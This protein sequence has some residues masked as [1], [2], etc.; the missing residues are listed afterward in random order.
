VIKTDNA[1]IEA[2]SSWVTPKNVHQVQQ[3]LGLAGYYRMFVPNF[4][5]IAHPLYQLTKSFVLWNWSLACQL[6][7]D[8]LKKLLISHPILRMPDFS[9]KFH[10]SCDA[11]G[12]A[13]GAILGQRDEDGKEYVICYI[14]RLLKGAELHYSV[15]EKEMLAVIWAIRQFRCYVYGREF[16]IITD[17]SALQYLLTVKDLNG[18]LAR[19][20]IYLQSYLFK[21][22]HRA[23][24]LHSNADALSRLA[25]YVNMINLLDHNVRNGKYD[26]VSMK[27]LDV[28]ENDHLLHFLEHS[29]HLPGTTKKQ[30]KYLARKAMH[31]VLEITHMDDDSIKK[32]IYYFKDKKDYSSKRIVPK[33]ADRQ[34]IIQDAHNLGHYSVEKTAQNISNVYYWRNLWHQVEVFIDSCL[35]C[36]RFKRSSV[37]NHPAIAIP[38]NDVMERIGIDLVLGLPLTESGYNGILVITEYLTKYPYAV[39]IRS[40]SAKEIARHLWHYFCLFGPA[41][42]LLSDCGKEFLNSVISEMLVQIGTIRRLDRYEFVHIFRH[43]F[44]FKHKFRIRKFFSHFHQVRLSDLPL[45]LEDV[46]LKAITITIKTIRSGS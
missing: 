25:S 22:I 17:H 33:P 28:W 9:K 19:W 37:L 43:K 3:F 36:L 42:E 39:A 7:F 40:K 2:V 6:A 38:I 4:A 8:T 12:L 30:I 46:S 32:V 44:K 16:E 31:Y 23:G 21:V 5:H 29:K 24:T 14:S 26:D 10:I 45:V 18:R 34:A 20:S 27:T 13:V 35:T 15:S 1:K 41:K 11:S